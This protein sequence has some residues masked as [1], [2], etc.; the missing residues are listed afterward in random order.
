MSS[1]WKVLRIRDVALGVYDGP[2]ATPPLADDGPIYLGIGNISDDG[3]LDLS[4][5]RHIA[6]ADFA[7]WTKR[8]TPRAGDIVFTYEATLN[9]YAIIPDNF[10]GCLGRRTALIRTDPTAVD[11]KFLF[12]SFFSREWRDTIEA[13]RLSGA[14]VDRIPIA[15]F[16]DFPIRLPPLT[17][18]R[19]IASILGAYDDLIEVNRR[20]I[21]ILEEMARRTYEEWFVYRRPLGS[22]LK[23]GEW[24][25]ERLAVAA[26]NFDRFRKP[27]SGK[28]RANRKGPYPYFGAAKIFD[29]IDSYIFDGVYLLFA[30]DGTV[31]TPDGFP[32]LQLTD[33]RFWPNNHTHVLQGSGKFSTHF[34]FLALKRY[35]I[36]G[37]ITGAAQPKIT[38]ANLNRILVPSAPPEVHSGF[39]EQVAPMFMLIASLERTRKNLAAQRDLLLPKLLSGEIEASDAPAV[40][41]A[42]E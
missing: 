34:L 21:A 39:D 19:R 13:N 36:N 14:T 10:R 4:D 23:G 24:G 9:R 1:D 35:P 33:G 7:D 3:H 15:K 26:Q 5:V 42:A 25:Q 37:H 32:V 41:E 38:Q 22:A 30:E 29:H 28:E 2:H 11:T 8:V 40:A 6:E 16:P 20:R 18:Q 17:T 31:I 12:Y 27:L